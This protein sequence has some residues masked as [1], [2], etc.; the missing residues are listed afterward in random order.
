[1]PRP[2]TSNDVKRHVWELVENDPKMSAGRILIALRARAT[3]TRIQLTLPTERTIARI[4]KDFVTKQPE[5]RRPFHY[6][7]WPEAMESGAV[8]WEASAA[9]LDLLQMF[10]QK[11]F[12]RPMIGTAAWFW[13][14][15][16]ARPDLDI[17]RRF[18]LANRCALLEAQDQKPG[19]AFQGVE[20]FLAMAPWRSK[21]ALQEYERV[22]RAGEI[23]ALPESPRLRDFAN[24]E[25]MAMA[26]IRQFHPA[27]PVVRK[28]IIER[29]VEK[30][31]RDRKVLTKRLGRE[32]TFNELCDEEERRQPQSRKDRKIR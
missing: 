17:A 29:F 15:T 8:P 31:R 7:S 19:D 26:A 24:N 12:D 9:M 25:E 3:K 2:G 18:D 16:Q 27:N 21:K 20:W 4:K 1:M 13:R 11:D 22:V 28:R 14:I 6:F 5:E 23:P 30:S 32:P 10:R